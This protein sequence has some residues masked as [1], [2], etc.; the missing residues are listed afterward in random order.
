LLGP[1]GAG[2]TSMFNV[3][4]SLV[5]KSKGSVKIKDIEVNKG[6]MEIY[7]DVGICPQFD[8]LW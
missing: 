7:Q 6:I 5:S 1:S 3:L 2:K 4:T 8:C